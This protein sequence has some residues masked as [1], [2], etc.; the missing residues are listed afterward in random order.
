[1]PGLHLG[2]IS[3]NYQCLEQTMQLI[4]KLTLFRHNMAVLY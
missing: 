3:S 1:M 2:L 4:L